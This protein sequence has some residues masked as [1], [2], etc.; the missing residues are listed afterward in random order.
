LIEHPELKQEKVIQVIQPPFPF[1]HPDTTLD[2][3][4]K[5]ITKDVNAV[6]VKS[7]AGEVHIITKQDVID[8][9]N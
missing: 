5:L 1:V 4:S 6:L 3:I 8:A 2:E 9:L 7:L